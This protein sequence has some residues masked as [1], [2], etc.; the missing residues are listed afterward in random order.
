VETE[1]K[2]TPVTLTVQG[3][4][5]GAAVRCNLVEDDA[6]ALPAKDHEV[7]VTVPRFSMATL[8]LV[9]Q[10]PAPVEIIK[11]QAEPLSDQ[12][13][14]VKWAASGKGSF[15]YNV[16]RS[17]D[18]REPPTVHTLIGRVTGTDYTDEGLSLDTTYYYQVAPVSRYNRQ[19]PVSPVV[20]ART[21][22]ANISP[23]TIVRGL[24]VVRRS[25]DLLIVYWR[26]NPEP[27]VRRYHLYRSLDGVFDMA[28]APLA[29]VE[30]TPQ[31]LQIFRDESVTPSTQYFYRVIAEDSA[32]NRQTE[33]PIASARTPD[34][35]TENDL[36]LHKG[37]EQ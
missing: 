24:G 11:P 26:K 36:A 1:G 3:F 34:P 32:G 9:P 16:F 33:A 37:D 14:R 35:L 18:P 10:E 13:I 15:A 8:R 7:K 2:D 21:S 12:S 31:F 25:T 23:P 17:T 4:P 5:V 6:E 27:D 30:A 28:S 20:S 19:G 29:T 22:R